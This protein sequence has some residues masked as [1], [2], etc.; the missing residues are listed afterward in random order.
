[1]PRDGLGLHF[2]TLDQAHVMAYFK[3]AHA[4][5]GY[6]SK[7]ADIITARL[8]NKRSLQRK[9][10]PHQAFHSLPVSSIVRRERIDNE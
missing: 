8:H 1:V 4:I 3:V 6:R 10:N 2:W 5:Y 9:R 7:Y